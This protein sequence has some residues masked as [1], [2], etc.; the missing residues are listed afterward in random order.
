MPAKASSFTKISSRQSQQGNSPFPIDHSQFHSQIELIKNRLR[1]LRLVVSS[2]SSFFFF[3]FHCTFFIRKF[4][5]STQ[6]K[7]ENISLKN[8][9]DSRMKL[10]HLKEKLPFLTQCIAINRQKTRFLRFV[11]KYRN[12]KMIWINKKIGKNWTKNIHDRVDK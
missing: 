10:R 4:G 3:L 8:V 6:I 5:K 11:W 9:K 12:K 7:D 1:I 2:S